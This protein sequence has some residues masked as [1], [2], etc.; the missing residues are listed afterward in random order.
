MALGSVPHLPGSLSHRRCSLDR[1][2][3]AE[4]FGEATGELVRAP[5]R[6]F[7]LLGCFPGAVGRELLW[8]QTAVGP[9]GLSVLQEDLRGEMARAVA[10][11][12][13]GGLCSLP[14]CASSGPRGVSCCFLL[15]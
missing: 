3:Q 6:H 4:L 15:C 7:P 11:Q 10:P 5:T 1:V 14:L 9:V 13:S 2:K 12:G 8:P